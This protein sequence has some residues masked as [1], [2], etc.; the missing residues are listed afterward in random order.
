MDN[1]PWSIVLLIQINSFSCLK[2]T[3]AA[4]VWGYF[5]SII[6]HTKQTIALIGAA[7]EKGAALARNMARGNYRILLFAHGCDDLD[8]LVSDIRKDVADADIEPITCSTDACWEAD[9][10]LLATAAD[11]NPEVV[12]KIRPVANQKVVVVMEDAGSQD[13]N[14]AF[15]LQSLLPHAKVVCAF[16]QVSAAQLQTAFTGGPK[17]EVLVSGTDADALQTTIELVQV[18]G[19]IPVVQAVQPVTAG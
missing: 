8:Q 12:E 18:A 15:F 14:P 19:C 11:T 2:I 9:I 16:T 3:V 13:T 6:M 5:C 1:C 4:T 10:I 7:D 17:P